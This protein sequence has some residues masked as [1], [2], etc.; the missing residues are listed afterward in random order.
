[1]GAPLEGKSVVEDG[2]ELMIEAVNAR[3]ALYDSFEAENSY[4]VSRGSGERI[5]LRSVDAWFFRVT[6]RLKM[7]CLQ[8]LA[9][10]RFRPPLNL[11]NEQQAAA[12]QVKVARRKKQRRRRRKREQEDEVSAYYYNI[13]EELNDFTEWCVSERNVWGIPVPFFY[14]KGSDRVFTNTD[15][16][17]HIAQLYRE[18]G[19]SDVWFRFSVS[20]LLPEKWRHLAPSLI[21]GDEVFDSWFESSLSWR[22]VLADKAT[23][24]NSQQRL[25]SGTRAL[26]RAQA[27]D[28]AATSTSSL[29][30]HQKQLPQ[31]DSTGLND[32]EINTGQLSSEELKQNLELILLQRP[33]E[34]SAGEYFLK[35]YVDEHFASS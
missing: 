33:T 35:Q 17:E 18:E 9:M 19:G 6:E 25:L 22:A 2:N 31:P 28:L 4:L 24:T 30:F 23:A 29:L 15:I 5:L 34:E 7:R 13:V 16:V 1:M 12:D 11:K 21:K 27:G 3:G 32:K 26:V 8:E 20:E 10:V 14:E